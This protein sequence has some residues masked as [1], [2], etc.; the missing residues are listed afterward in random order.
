MLNEN[1]TPTPH[2]CI[3]LAGLAIEP[4]NF[5][6]PLQNKLLIYGRKCLYGVS[7]YLVSGI[8]QINR[9]V[10]KELEKSLYPDGFTLDR[11]MLQRSSR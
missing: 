4:G 2:S 5:P 11:P 7:L 3:L 9:F 1:G 6:V 10:F 8:F